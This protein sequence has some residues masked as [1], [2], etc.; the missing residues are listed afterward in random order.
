MK[1]KA[2]DHLPGFLYAQELTQSRIR[3]YQKPLDNRLLS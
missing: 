2:G 1:Q 3:F